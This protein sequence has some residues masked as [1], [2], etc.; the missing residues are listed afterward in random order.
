[1][2]FA[3]CTQTGNAYYFKI[4]TF[5]CSSL[6]CRLASK[7]FARRVHT[8][9]NSL[10][11]TNRITTHY[12]VVS[13]DNDPRWKGTVVTRGNYAIITYSLLDIDMERVSDETDV[14]IIGGGP[15]G[16]SAAIRLKQ[17]AAESGSEIRVCVVEKASQIG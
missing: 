1:M 2:Q 13:R 7:K 4:L 9:R 8:G 11:A 17:L 14:V 16:L 5:C 15:A 10:A 6:G 3:R 12:T